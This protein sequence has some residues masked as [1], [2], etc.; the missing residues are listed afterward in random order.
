MKVLLAERKANNKPRPDRTPFQDVLRSSDIVSLHCP[1]TEETRGLIGR[2]EL[3]LM[4]ADAIL[5]NCARGGLINDGA[6]ARALKEGWIGGAGLDSVSV[7]PPRDENPLLQEGVP[8]LVVTPHVAWA[9]KQ[10]LNAFG[11]QLVTNIEAFV[12][13]RFQ[14]RIS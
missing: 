3:Q 12:L 1:L 14:N 7:E 5:I 10:A 13:G 9:S 2:A 8:N 6:L 11:E 4:K